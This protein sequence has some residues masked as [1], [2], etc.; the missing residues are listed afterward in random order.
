[1]DQYD[2]CDNTPYTSVADG[3]R[4]SP[5]MF[6]S[7]NKNKSWNESI[8]LG[9]VLVNVNHKYGTFEAD[10]YTVRYLTEIYSGND[11]KDHMSRFVL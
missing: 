8:K 2:K 1:M 5:H 11:L 7:L 4:R 9:F 3:D 6:V 10:N